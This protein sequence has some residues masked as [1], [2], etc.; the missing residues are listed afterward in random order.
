MAKRREKDHSDAVA[1]RLA[2]YSY[3]QIKDKLKVSKS[4]LSGWLDKYPLTPQ[5]IKEL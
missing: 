5:G 3:S 1:L 4:T 2:G